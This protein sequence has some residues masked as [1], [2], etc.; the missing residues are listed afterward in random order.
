MLKFV[1]ALIEVEITKGD[2]RPCRIRFNHTTSATIEFN[3][4]VLGGGGKGRG[5]NEGTQKE[6]RGRERERE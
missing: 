1:C 5:V 4:C 3:L 2:S 6:G